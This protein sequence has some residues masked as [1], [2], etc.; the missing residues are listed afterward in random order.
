M[1]VL[2]LVEAQEAMDQQ[3]LEVE[4]EVVRKVFPWAWG[5]EAEPG[6]GD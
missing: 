2:A 5:S 4:S 1:E 6:V 3:E